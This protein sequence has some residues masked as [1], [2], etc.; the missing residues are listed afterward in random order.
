M[1]RSRWSEFEDAEV[2]ASGPLAE[3][4]FAT[5]QQEWQLL[6]AAA[7]VGLGDSAK[8]VGVQYAKDRSAFGVPIGTFQAIAHP[9]A[10][11]AIGIEGAATFDVEGVLVRG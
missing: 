8:D 9:L 3:R 7:L 4:A 1:R 11:V 5:A 2:L 6:I 10:D